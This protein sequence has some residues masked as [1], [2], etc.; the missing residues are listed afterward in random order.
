MI[1]LKFDQQG[2]IPAVVQHDQTKQVLMV[3]WMN[4]EAFNLTIKTKKIH[5]WS[6]SR[7][8]L[9]LK[10]ETSGNF[11]NLV[12]IYA[13]CDQDTLLLFALPDGPTCHT[14]AVSC[15]FEKI[16]PVNSPL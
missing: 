8:K 16:Y 6:R 3:G 9:W 7:Q 2:L 12:E 15:F 4:Q 11:L 1:N 10:G 5:F 13:D 14:G